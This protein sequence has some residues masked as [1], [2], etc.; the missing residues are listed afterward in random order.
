MENNTGMYEEKSFVLPDGK[1]YLTSALIT[2]AAISASP[3]F[4]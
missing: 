4:M 3:G 1:Q 2:N